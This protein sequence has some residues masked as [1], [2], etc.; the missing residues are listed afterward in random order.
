MVLGMVT[1]G[2]VKSVDA[3]EGDYF[4]RCLRGGSERGKAASHGGSGLLLLQRYGTLDA[5]L[6]E[7][8][9]FT[10]PPR[11]LPETAAS[12]GAT[13]RP[14]FRELM[15]TVRRVFSKLIMRSTTI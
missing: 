9:G 14:R 5:K 15:P 1:T 3:A 8:S 6:D 11:H 7:D 4:E 12:S 13:W 2:T 10:L